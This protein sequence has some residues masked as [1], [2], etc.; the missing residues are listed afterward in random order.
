MY[1]PNTSCHIIGESGWR[2]KSD[3]QPGH[4]RKPSRT[5][6]D[7]YKTKYSMQQRLRANWRVLM[8]RRIGHIQRDHT[9]TCKT[10]PGQ[11]D[12]YIK[13]N[14]RCGKGYAPTGGY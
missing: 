12:G 13:P 8:G 10:R 7:G 9:H 4:T 11:T 5:E 3:I 1:L 6:V 2:A 14:I